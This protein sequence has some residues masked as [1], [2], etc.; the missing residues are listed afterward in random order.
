MELKGKVVLVTGGASGIGRALALRF[1]QDGAAGVAVCDLD[2]AGAQAVAGEIGERAIAIG[3]DV[4][5]AAQVA[6]SIDR[7]E[8]ELG[9]VALYCANAGI[10]AGVGLNTP[11]DV[12]DLALAVNVRSHVY[13]ARELVPRWLER[14]EGYFLSTASAAGLLT[15]VGSAPYA[16]TKHGAVAFAEWL[17]V[18]Y[19]G[20]GVRVSCLC[21][22]AV[23]TPLL[24][25]GADSGD[26]EGVVATKVVQAAGATMQPEEVAGIVVEGLRSERFLILPHPEVL[27]FFQRKGSDYD[28]WIA[29]MQRLQASL[30]G[31]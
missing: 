13:A 18:T 25:A 2:E 24:H 10:G 6:A 11:D 21:P 27:E 3:C 19:G 23:E 22:M 14:G 30:G 8:R 5:D 4:A 20:R 31:G 9:P 16:V 28:R 7:A 17:S 26:P 1:A 12:W 15:Q 29:G